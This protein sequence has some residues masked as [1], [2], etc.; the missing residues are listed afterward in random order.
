MRANLTEDDMIN[1]ENKLNATIN[2]SKHV[3]GHVS[4]FGISTKWALAELSH[5]A[6]FQVKWQ[7]SDIN[8][9]GRVWLF[10]S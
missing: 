9:L 7:V 1:R 4:K 6:A 2:I 5:R 10:V 3:L 8:R